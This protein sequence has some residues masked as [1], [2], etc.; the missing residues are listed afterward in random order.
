M[1]KYDKSEQNTWHME[2][3]TT[4]ERSLLP[5][6]EL[7]LKRFKE[8]HCNKIINGGLQFNL[9]SWLKNQLSSLTA[10]LQKDLL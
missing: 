4:K 5:S 8:K 1:Y 2:I 6:K 3:A 9:N 7:H 10:Y